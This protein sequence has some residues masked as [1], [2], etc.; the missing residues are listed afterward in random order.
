MLDFNWV[1]V[2]VIRKTSQ[3][4]EWPLV[5]KELRKEFLQG[6]YQLLYNGEVIKNGCFGEGTNKTI[7][8]RISAYRSMIKILSDVRTGR[9]AKNGSF[10]TVDLLDKNLKVGEEVIMRAIK[11]PN[12]KID[13]NGLPWKVDLYELENALKQQHKDTI[14]LI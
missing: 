4:L 9:K 12:N 13:E 5:S 10:N 8:R 7:N 11:L 14:W 6:V 1:E 3:G 2:S